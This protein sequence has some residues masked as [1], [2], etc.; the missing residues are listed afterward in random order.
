MKR[1]VVVCGSTN[2]MR[3]PCADFAGG[4][5]F[6]RQRVWLRCPAARVS[7]V[8][9]AD[10]LASPRTPKFERRCPAAAPQ[11]ATKGSAKAIQRGVVYAYVSAAATLRNRSF[12]QRTRRRHC[13]HKTHRS[14]FLFQGALTLCVGGRTFPQ[15]LQLRAKVLSTTKCLRERTPTFVAEAKQRQ[16]QTTIT[17]PQVRRLAA[18]TF[19]LAALAATSSSSCAI[20][21][22]KAASRSSADVYC[23][24]R[25]NLALSVFCVVVCACSSLVKARCA[26]ANDWYCGST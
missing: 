7:S 8:N 6:G 14:D 21:S 13:T 19:V 2:R 12:A 1:A 23:R 4:S 26:S 9:P 17:S 16:Q 10:F 20:S 25:C 18:R 11:A 22:S 15:L 3:A 24:W 5:R